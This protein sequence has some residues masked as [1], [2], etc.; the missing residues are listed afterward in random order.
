MA[1]H[2]EFDRDEALQ[3]AMEVFWSR[4]YEAASINDLVNHIGVNRQSL[5]DTFGDKHSLYLQALDRYNEAECRK[6]FELLERPGSVRKALRELF[7][8]VIEESLSDQRRRGCFM[9][10]AMSELAG[11]CPETAAK[12]GYQ[13]TYAVNALH[14]ALL[15]G[16]KEGEIK[17]T[18]DLRAV[19]FFLHNS[20]QG[21]HLTAKAT[22]DRKPLEDIMKIT[23]STLD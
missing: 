17:G 5:Y 16:K 15:R 12:A 13:M 22:Q 18:R 19:A 21:L 7:H 9:G 4:G 10:N 6:L 23:L 8:S 11:R 20:L 1:R 3:K 2:K 14:R